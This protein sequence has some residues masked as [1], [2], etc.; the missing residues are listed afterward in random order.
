MH[1]DETVD[2]YLLNELTEPERQEL[3][4]R[5]L[6]EDALFDMISD[7]ENQWLDAYAR[8]SLSDADRRRFEAGYLV[9][10]RR[11]SNARFAEAL[12]T[13]LTRRR[14]H[15]STMPARARHPIYEMLVSFFEWESPALRFAMVAAL[16]ILVFGTA[17]ILRRPAVDP[18]T[19]SDVIASVDPAKREAI[20]TEQPT[21]PP[22]G[23]VVASAEPPAE[24]AEVPTVPAARR[25]VEKIIPFTIAVATL[26]SNAS[27]PTL[28]LTQDAESVALSLT[29]EDEPFD[30][31]GITILDP[32][33]NEAWTLNGIEARRIDGVQTI[34]AQ[35]PVG[36]L[37]EGTHEI[38]LRGGT[39][40]GAEEIA[41]IELRVERKRK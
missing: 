17:A 6:A 41:F 29:T 5:M 1:T 11:R 28:E 19:A 30:R 15:T 39:G 31:F 34:S 35:V 18:S 26:R 13:S 9:N 2:R 20:T 25:R 33:G 27:V 23:S 21:T 4:N 24:A 7:A 37:S 3:E 32:A 16:L 10:E 38:L 36:S 22:A 8:R 40:D 14:A 12:N